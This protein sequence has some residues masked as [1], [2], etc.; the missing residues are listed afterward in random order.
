ML[1]TYLGPFWVISDM[2]EIG[3]IQVMCLGNLGDKLWTCN[4]HVSK[5]IGT[6]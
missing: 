5:K 6:G 2:L 3:D 4:G 1:G